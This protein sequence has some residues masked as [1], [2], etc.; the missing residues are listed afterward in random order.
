MMILRIDHTRLLITLCAAFALLA[1]SLL[2]AAPPARA[3][4]APNSVTLFSDDAV[5]APSSSVLFEARVVT[6]GALATG[7]V[8]FKE[9]SRTIGSPA[10]LNPS[11][12]NTYASAV[13][14]MF[15]STIGSSGKFVITATYS[16]DSNYTSTVSAGICQ[17]IDS[18]AGLDLSGCDFSAS[19]L[20]SPNMTNTN[21][22]NSNFFNATI[23]S[24]NLSGANFSGAI[25]TG[26]NSSGLIGTPSSL[27]SGWS[28]LGGSFVYTAP[29][30]SAPAVETPTQ[31][32][33]TGLAARTVGAKKKYSAKTLARQVGVPIVSSKATVSISVAKS[34]KKVCTKSGA[35]L[36]TLKA[37]NCNVTFTVQEPKPKNGKKP[38]ATKT[39]TTLIVQ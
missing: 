9:G 15:G 13:I 22:T 28:I 8:T 14:S 2:L 10:T 18:G 16:G 32:I 35:K 1:S 5:V 24:G 20:R 7:T 34:S 36:R 27:P 6:S 26:V 12:D 29:T 39:P 30:T 31:V 33:D 3:A 23:T 38:K 19:T 21:L 37:G 25:L 17:V 4:V 11:S